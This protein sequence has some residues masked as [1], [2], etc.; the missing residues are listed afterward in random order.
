MKICLKLGKDASEIR[1]IIKNALYEDDVMDLLN[2]FEWHKL[3]SE[4]KEQVENAND[5]I[6]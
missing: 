5:A 4:G 3:S 1:K 6:Q 2:V